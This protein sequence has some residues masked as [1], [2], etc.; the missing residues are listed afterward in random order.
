[1]T[2][3][4][5]QV[6]QGGSSPHLHMHWKPAV[7]LGRTYVEACF[8]SF[9]TINTTAKKEI[10]SKQVKETNFRTGEMAR[11]EIKSSVAHM[12]AHNG[13]NFSFRGTYALFGLQAHQGRK[14]V[15]KYTGR[16]NKN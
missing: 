9:A 1:M 15:H 5:L 7:F 10:M 8:R 12:V 11:G 13:P 16:Q 3:D 6:V 2:Y 4:V 14:V